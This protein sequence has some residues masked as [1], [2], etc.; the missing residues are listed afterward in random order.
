MD[1]FAQRVAGAIEAARLR[2]THDLPGGATVRYVFWDPS[3]GPEEFMRRADAD[4]HDAKAMQRT[5]SRE[6][7]S[8]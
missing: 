8:V 3:E 6:A 2:L 4:L 7:E 1:S 5:A